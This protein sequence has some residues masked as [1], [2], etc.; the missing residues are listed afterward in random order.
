MY[1]MP[2]KCSKSKHSSCGVG[3]KSWAHSRG[4]HHHFHLSAQEGKWKQELICLKTSEVFG[5]PGAEL[6]SKG[7]HRTEELSVPPA[8]FSDFWKCWNFLPGTGQGTGSVLAQTPPP[9]SHFAALCLYKYRFLS[10]YAHIHIKHGY[11]HMNSFSCLQVL[12]Q[13]KIIRVVNAMGHLW[14]LGN[15]SAGGHS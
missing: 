7:W 3:E 1:I 8:G 14:T 13:N 12:K 6:I 10:G 2:E 15:F 4:S 9:L 5:R 11:G